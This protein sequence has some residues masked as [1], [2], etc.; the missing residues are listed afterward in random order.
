[1]DHLVEQTYSPALTGDVWLHDALTSFDV[2]AALASALT[3]AWSV[4]R[5]I[6]P[7]GDLSIIVLPPYDDP[8]YSAFVI[9][10]ENG[11]VQV[12]TI[13]GDAWQ[14]RRAFPTCQRAVA[15]IIAAAC[16]CQRLRND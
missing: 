13:V 3:P 14:G 8:A 4:E 5:E 6:D 12:A 2:V 15:A 9:Y 11:F 1:M 16:S 7:A 10:E